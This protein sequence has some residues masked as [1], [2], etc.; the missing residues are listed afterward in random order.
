MGYIQIVRLALKI[1]PHIQGFVHVQTNPDYAEST[2]KTIANAFRIVQIFHYLAPDFDPARVCIKIP[3][4]WEGLMACKT[5]EMAG[6]RTLAIT[7]FT[8]V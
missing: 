3:S 5:L 2:E 7:L 4:T 8:F 6:V 1:A